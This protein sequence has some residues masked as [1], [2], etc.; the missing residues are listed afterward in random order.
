MKRDLT[1]EFLSYLQVERGLSKNSLASYKRD[2]AKLKEFAKRE[3]LRLVEISR[4]DLRAFI[5]DLSRSGLSP[6][7][8]GRIVSAIRGFYKFLLLDGHVKNYPAENLAVPKKGF[9]LP[10][11]LTEDEIEKLLSQPDVATEIGLR[12]RAILELIYAS[13]LRV[14]EA[15]NLQIDNIDIDAGILTCL[16]K[17]HKERKVPIGKSAIKWLKN[18]LAKRSKKEHIEMRNLF[19][20]NLSKPITRQTIFKFIKEYA[21]KAGLKDVS[22]H[23]IRHTFATHLLQR[24][25]DSRSVQSMLGHADISTTQIYTH[26][27]DL[28]LRKTYEKF[29]PRANLKIASRMK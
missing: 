6:N 15:S 2:L 24:G 21:A 11:F 17:G 3:R 29:H 1:E 16:G 18:Y 14:S 5:I 7:S 13:G 23:T 9:Y 28:H 26:I 25:A 12:N 10:R 19:V 22:P 27:T 4:T 20:T 8:I